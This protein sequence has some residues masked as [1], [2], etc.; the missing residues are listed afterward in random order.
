MNGRAKGVLMDTAKTIV[1]Y[2]VQICRLCHLSSESALPEARSSRVCTL[3]S[4][5]AILLVYSMIWHG[6]ALLLFRVSASNHMK[7]RFLDFEII[8][9]FH[10]RTQWLV[11]EY[12]PFITQ[13]CRRPMMGIILGDP[14]F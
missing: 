6:L 4:L 10:L 11:P 9:K 2:Y 5:S 13:L 12:L 8:T 14:S 1:S 7:Y 3:V